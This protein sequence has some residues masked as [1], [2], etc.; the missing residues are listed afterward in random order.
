M[1]RKKFFRKT[2]WFFL[3]LPFEL[4]EFGFMYIPVGVFFLLTI[5]V[6]MRL[7]EYGGFGIAGMIA[8]VVM[9]PFLL[10]HA[11]KRYDRILAMLKFRV[12]RWVG[13]RKKKWNISRNDGKHRE[14]F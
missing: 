5:Y 2:L 10:F 9:V 6:M 4:L 3:M 1:K 11:C 8:Y 13:R 7:P 12:L 14:V